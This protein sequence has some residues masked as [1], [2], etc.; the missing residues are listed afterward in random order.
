MSVK[1]D[2]NKRVFGNIGDA[3]YNASFMSKEALFQISDLL[4]LDISQ[5]N[6]H[7]Q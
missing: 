7:R 6:Y 1:Q 3:L 5:E 4:N 2:I